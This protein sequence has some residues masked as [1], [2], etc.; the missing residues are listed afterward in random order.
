MDQLNK[1][2]KQLNSGNIQEI[3][4]AIVAII[5][6]VSTIAGLVSSGDLSSSNSGTSASSPA[7]GSNNT[8][9]KSMPATDTWVWTNG[10][11][12]SNTQVSINGKTYSNSFVNTYSE[13]TQDSYWIRPNRNDPDVEFK[14]LTATLGFDDNTLKN[15]RPAYVRVQ[16]EVGGKQVLNEI[17]RPGQVKNIRFDIAR[18]SSGASKNIDFRLTG[19]DSKNAE[20]PISGIAIAN[21]QLHY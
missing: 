9:T 8:A 20:A 10:R 12:D 19:Y 18:Y 3:A 5:A 6:A 13:T 1:I 17:V 4:A 7:A 21:P 11:G 2:L 14:Y 16:A 15:Q